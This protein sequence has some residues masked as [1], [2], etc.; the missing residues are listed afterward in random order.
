MPSF[1][2]D[3]WGTV[4]RASPDDVEAVKVVRAPG[5]GFLVLTRDASGE[6]DVWMETCEEI[7]ADLAR[8]DPRWP[9]DASQRGNE[10]S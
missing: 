9:V 8:M 7:E 3:V 1:P 5:G 2:L 10:A 6:H 4:L